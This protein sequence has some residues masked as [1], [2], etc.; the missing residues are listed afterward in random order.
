[1]AIRNPAGSGPGRGT[2][3]TRTTARSGERAHRE[4]RS[5][6]VYNENNVGVEADP[7]RPST[8]GITWRLIVLAVAFFGIAIVL[9]QSLRI[10]FLQAADVAKVRAEI[11]A[12]Q[13]EIS[14]QK[15]E[16]SRWQSPD[17]VRSQ[18]RVRLGWVLPGEV[19]YRVIGPDG[20]PLD[21]D[22]IIQQETEDPGPW[23]QRMWDSV[24]LADQPEPEVS[25]AQTP[26]PATDDRVIR[27]ETE[28]PKP[29]PSPS[30]S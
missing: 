10:Y 14:R 7:P 23:Y 15:E 6:P 17:Y 25:A 8:G 5:T 16:I 19:G 3:R 12:T 22:S 13:E 9:A 30:Q 2:P 27:L 1:M 29:E 4:R 11:A 21:G 18:A 28:L 20:K 24:A 26:R